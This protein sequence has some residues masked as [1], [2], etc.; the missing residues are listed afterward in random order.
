MSAGK[1]PIF[2]AVRQ[3]AQGE[4]EDVLSDPRWD[5]YA[6]GTA[7]EEDIAALRALAE[8]DPLAREAL[9]A[10][11]PFDASQRARFAE[12]VAALPKPPEAVTPTAAA[13]AKV[14]ALDA[15]RAKPSRLP[16]VLGALALAAAVSF[17]LIPRQDPETPTFP[18]YSLVVEGAVGERS[19]GAPLAL[20]PGGRL[21]VRLR[22]VSASSAPVNARAFVV[23][24][25]TALVLEGKVDVSDDGA[26]R[27][28]GRLPTNLGLGNA[29]LVVVVGAPAA[30][31][32]VPLDTIE[33]VVDSAD[34][35]VFHSSLVLGAGP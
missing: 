6:A 33:S 7:S 13:G 31:A 26:A 30:V 23:Q 29:T 12:A 24:G 2:A 25:A 9:D 27:F 22:P 15:R 35:R 3:V 17:A 34:L 5:A 16:M 28:E 18:A 8:K 19:D 4:A 14:I 20:S 11:A 21:A 32:A 10:L 1:Q